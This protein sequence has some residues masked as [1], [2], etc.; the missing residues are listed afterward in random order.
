MQ[1]LDPGGLLEYL[2]RCSDVQGDTAREPH[3]AAEEPGSGHLAERGPGERGAGLELD[4]RDI[5]QLR[6]EGG[7]GPPTGEAPAIGGEVFSEEEPGPV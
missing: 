3:R 4:P 1:P 2:V 6:C 5:P 7:A